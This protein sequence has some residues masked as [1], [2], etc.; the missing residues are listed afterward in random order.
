MLTFLVTFNIRVESGGWL[1]PGGFY[2]RIIVNGTDYA[3]NT[4]GFNI[5]VV[6]GKTG[7]YR[8]LIIMVLR[9]RSWPLYLQAC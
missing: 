3:K 7:S 9:L 1:D 8:L 2:A 5:V 4:R 6:D